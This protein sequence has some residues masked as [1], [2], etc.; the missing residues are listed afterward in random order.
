MTIPDSIELLIVVLLVLVCLYIVQKMVLNAAQDRRAEK[1]WQ[2]NRIHDEIYLEE[3][4]QAW[5]AKKERE[6]TTSEKDNDLIPD[7]PDDLVD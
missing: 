2:I 4:L 5:C 6:K 3:H 7:T 1:D